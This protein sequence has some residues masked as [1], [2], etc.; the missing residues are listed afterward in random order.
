M[1]LSPH[2]T[3]RHR[4]PTLTDNQSEAVRQGDFSIKTVTQEHKDDAFSLMMFMLSGV[5]G[6]KA[7]AQLED[8]C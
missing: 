2:I 1:A 5:V 4:I 8:Q 6:R 7:N 3:V